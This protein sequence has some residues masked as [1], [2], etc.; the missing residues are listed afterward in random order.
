V[1]HVIVVHPEEV[2]P[3][4]RDVYVQVSLNRH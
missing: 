4:S 3:D 2:T 1:V